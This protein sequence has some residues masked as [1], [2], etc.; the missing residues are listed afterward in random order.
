MGMFFVAAFVMTGCTHDQKA[1]SAA[2][3]D[4]SDE[5]AVATMEEIAGIVM[6]GPVGVESIVANEPGA[7]LTVATT[8]QC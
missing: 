3:A 6:S 4:V 5:E 7:A 1:A 8:A 2:R